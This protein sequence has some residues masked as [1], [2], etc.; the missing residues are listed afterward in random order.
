MPD[1]FD[2]LF[3]VLPIVLVIVWILRRVS[4][5]ARKNNDST[6]EAASGDHPGA[7]VRSRRMNPKMN[8]AESYSQV[9]SGSSEQPGR[10]T[11]LKGV[12]ARVAEFTESIQEKP[13]V[14]SE[15]FPGGNNFPGSNNVVRQV[16]NTRSLVVGDRLDV[17]K[18]EA[19][20]SFKE[21]EAGLGSLERISKLSPLAQ[22]MLWS[23]ILDKPVGMKDPSEGSR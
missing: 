18:D 10:E 22:G 5:K 3:S 1:V 2:N 20:V 14:S 4:R 23:T 7:G 6:N 11:R 8:P 12:L 13:S 9:G 16:E 17:E 19:M 15:P 21:Q